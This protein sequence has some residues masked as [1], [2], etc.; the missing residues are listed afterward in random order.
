MSCLGIDPGS[1]LRLVV[2]LIDPGSDVRL[3]LELI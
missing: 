3:V 2:A 1:D